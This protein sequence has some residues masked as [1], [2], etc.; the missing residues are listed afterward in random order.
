MIQSDIFYIV[1]RLLSLVMGLCI[2]EVCPE[3]VMIPIKI[4]TGIV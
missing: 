2:S 1:L 3:V 4:S